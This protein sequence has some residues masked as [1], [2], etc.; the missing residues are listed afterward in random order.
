MPSLK[1]LSYNIHKGFSA[2]NRR[3]VLSSIKQA[4]RSVDADIVFLQEV[5]GHHKDHHRRLPDT[6]LSSQFEYLADEIWPHFA[7]GKNSIYDDGHHGNAILSRIPIVE[8]T[9]IDISTNSFERRGILHVVLDPQVTSSEGN[10]FP[11]HCICVH[12]DLLHRGRVQQIHQLCERIS[13]FLPRDHPFI[14][15]GDFND[16]SVRLS[17]V[18]ER[19]TGGIE[20]FRALNGKHAPTFPSQYPLFRLDRIYTRGMRPISAKVLSGPLWKNLS[21]HAALF[22]ELGKDVK[23]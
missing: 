1:V 17:Q 11:L 10:D 22:A 18:V 4:I 9:N 3:F 20:V 13:S 6:G 8:W 7:Y 23:K 14:L 21:D 12:L 16:W 19:D 2:G 15:A 5:V